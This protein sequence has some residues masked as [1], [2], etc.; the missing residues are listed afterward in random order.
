MPTRDILKVL[1]SL[2]ESK[3]IAEQQKVLVEQQK[4]LVEQ[5]QAEFLEHKL[6]EANMKLLVEKGRVNL[7]LLLEM[8]L[9]SPSAQN[10]DIGK[11]ASEIKAWIVRDQQALA[12]P[13]APFA[14]VPFASSLS[15]PTRPCSL[16]GLPRLLPARGEAQPGGTAHSTH[17]RKQDQRP[18]VQCLLRVPPRQHPRVSR[19]LQRHCGCP[20]GVV[21]QDGGGH[22]RH[23]PPHPHPHP[24]RAHLTPRASTPTPSASTPTPSALLTAPYTTGTG[25]LS[26]TTTARTCRRARPPTPDGCRQHHHQR[27]D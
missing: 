11:S 2:F 19:S 15:Q 8:I 9:P 6:K 17:S 1:S 5:R 27:S 4:V 21:A 20:P 16:A 7:R 12:I 25:C 10:P 26:I 18:L 23:V 3:L 13:H 24:A 22:P 14:P